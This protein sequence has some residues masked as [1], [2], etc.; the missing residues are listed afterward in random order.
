MFGWR[1][2]NATSPCCA[3]W[4]VRAC[5]ISYPRQTLQSNVYK[6]FWYTTLVHVAVRYDQFFIADQNCSQNIPDKHSHTFSLFCCL[7]GHLCIMKYLIDEQGC[8]PSCLDRNQQSPLHCAGHNGQLDIVK[9]L[10]TLKKCCNPEKAHSPSDHS[11]TRPQFSSLL[12]T[13]V[14]PMQEVNIIQ[15]PI[16]WLK[17][18][19]ISK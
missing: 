15:Y 19:D 12:R 10:N 1:Q 14:L 16:S 8:D 2:K 18:R 6:L 13:S 11:K 7:G 17:A 4:T 3:Q 5:T 9:F